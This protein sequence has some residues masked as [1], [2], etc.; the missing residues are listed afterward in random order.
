MIKKVFKYFILTFI[1]VL[2]VYNTNNYV[3][4]DSKELIL[5]DLSLNIDNVLLV[6]DFYKIQHSRIVLAQSILET[7]Y[8]SSKV[9]KEYNNILGLYNSKEKDYYR[10]NHWSECIKKFPSLVQYKYPGGCY[11]TWLKELPYAEDPKYIKKIKI[12]ER[13]LND[14]R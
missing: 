2:L 12:I 3:K 8:Y 11:Y 6:L 4:K 5:T 14:K 13:R 1:G 7:G 10:F 9:C